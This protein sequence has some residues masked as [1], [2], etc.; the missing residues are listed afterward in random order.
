MEAGG[1]GS[2][3]L[4]LR[5]FLFLFQVDVTSMGRFGSS[6]WLSGCAFFSFNLQLLGEEKG[7]DEV[8]VRRPEGDV[9]LVD[10]HHVGGRVEAILLGGEIVGERQRR[11]VSRCAEGDAHC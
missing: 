3:A 5:S 8:G 11:E 4:V 7:S 2:I 9:A 10:V 1:L 6:G